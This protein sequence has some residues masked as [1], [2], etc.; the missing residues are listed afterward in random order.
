M[1]YSVEHSV[2]L[3]SNF[4]I[5]SFIRMTSEGQLTAHVRRFEG[6]T[7]GTIRLYSSIE[8]DGELTEIF[9]KDWEDSLEYVEIVSD[10]EVNFEYLAIAAEFSTGEGKVEVKIKN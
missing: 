4:P 7:A 3:R 1:P 2:I 10:A 9:S 6:N 5:P 8:P